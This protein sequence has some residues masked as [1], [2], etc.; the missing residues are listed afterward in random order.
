MNKLRLYIP[1]GLIFLVLLLHHVKYD[2]LLL[3]F[4]N[5][6]VFLHS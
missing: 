5:K 4:F 2:K 1:E 6:D 3:Y